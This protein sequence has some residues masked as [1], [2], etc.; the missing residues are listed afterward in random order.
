MKVFIITQNEPF[1]IPKMINELIKDS[2]QS[3]YQIAGITM[4]APHRKNKTIRN[5]INERKRIYNFKEL[6]LV[7]LAFFIATILNILKRKNSS[8]SVK[9]IAMKND[10]ALFPT[11]DINDN[12]FVETLIKLNIDLIIS[13]SCPQLFRKELLSIPRFA[14]INAH[15]TLLPRHRGVFGSWW[16]LFCDDK[17]GGST[18]HTMVEEVDKGEIIWQ[19]SFKIEKHH[20][21]FSIAHQTKKD[22]AFGLKQV[23]M[24]Y[25]NGNILSLNP[26]Y[27][28]SYHYAPSKALGDE[29]HRKGKRVIRF[30][31]LKNMLSRNFEQ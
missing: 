23:I 21:Q 27:D 1:Y 18:I 22:M 16:M 6:V 25:K 10:I 13:I 20:T 12:N 3:N 7:A 31:D 19:Q 29:F 9:Y 8:Y 24:N 4:L 15:G 26:Q 2:N 17:M 14:C 28:S 11:N 5:W 30:W